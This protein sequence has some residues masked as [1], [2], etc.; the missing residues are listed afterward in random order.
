M[1]LFFVHGQSFYTLLNHYSDSDPDPNA[2]QT[3]K[4]VYSGKKQN[5]KKLFRRLLHHIFV[6]NMRVTKTRN[7][8]TRQVYVCKGLNERLGDVRNYEKNKLKIIEK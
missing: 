8:Y 4:K 6:T 1:L 3:K 5:C 2:G 7:L